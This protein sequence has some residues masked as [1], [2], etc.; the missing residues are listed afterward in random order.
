MIGLEYHLPAQAGKAAAALFGL[1]LGVYLLTSGGHFYAVD[2]EMMFNVTEGL[3]LHGSFALNPDQPDTLTKYSQYGPGQSIAAVPLFWLG[4]AVTALFPPAI[5]PWLIRAIVG[6]FNPI[7]TAGV[8]ALLY[9]AVRLLGFRHR[10]ATVTA[11]LYGLGTMAWPQ[12]KTFFAEPLTALL[13]FGSFIL[14][15]IAKPRDE[16]HA[17][18]WLPF[19]LAGLLA[20]F[21]PAVKIQ[22]GIALPLL[23][24]FALLQALRLG[25]R[26][27]RTAVAPLAAW[28]A[29]AALPLV[30]LGFYQLAA[31]GS[32]LRTGYGGTVLDQFT[33][34]FWV[35]FNGQIWSSGRG[36]IWYAPPL[37]LFP[38]GVV[39]LWRRHWPTAALCALMFIVHVLFYA[40]WN[41]WD[42]A[43]A[44]GPR[45]LNAILPF[46]ALPLAAFLDTPRG[47]WARL[48]NGVLIVLALLAIP[49]QLGGLLISVNTFFSRTRPLDL[50][51]YRVAD[52]AIAWH[53]KIAA[54]QLRQSYDTYLAPES[55]AL[56]SG[57]S[58]SEGGAAQVPRWTLPQAVIGVRPPK[59]GVL[60]LV[61]GLNGCWS[62]PGPSPITISSAGTVLVRDDTACPSRTY[63][64]ALPTRSTKLTISAQPWN[65]ATFGDERDE[66]LG[67]LLQQITAQVD[68]QPLTLQGETLPVAPMPLNSYD[69][70]HWMGDHR[71]H[72]WDFWWWYLLHDRLSITSN[73]L[74]SGIWLVAALGSGGWGLY[75]LTRSSAKS[76]ADDAQKSSVE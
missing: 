69:I 9:V 72:H 70:R 1:L 50:S 40:K 34:P 57:F 35:G 30:L 65:P 73:L 24:L 56:L 31:F 76:D 6:W 22:A 29:G 47:R 59:G 38:L 11:L 13:F 14:L 28:L 46:M 27:D 25:A 52:S 53:L 7:V 37:L 61:I 39:L 60:Q 74:L 64:F 3:A 26:P 48:R 54:E 12:S 67:T 71:I 68:G 4:S 63:R 16:P 75:Q 19:L 42:G 21:A 20:G 17:R 18:P 36:I 10:I 45:F 44:W 15:L 62:K 5:Y 49:V 32:P 58:Y 33:T 23:S 8:A 51:Y 41:A 55:V 43:G 2:E 66:E